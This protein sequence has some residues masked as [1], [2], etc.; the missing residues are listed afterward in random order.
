MLLKRP[1]MVRDGRARVPRG[2]SEN[3]PGIVGRWRG[4]VEQGRPGDRA[5]TSRGLWDDGEGR[6]TL[7]IGQ[8][9]SGDCGTMARVGRGCPGD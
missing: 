8:G 5:G 3:I 4:T 2:L 9:R 6:D 1:A 7:G